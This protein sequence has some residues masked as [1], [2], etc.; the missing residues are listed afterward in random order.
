MTGARAILER[1]ALEP[2][3]P[4]L[5][6]RI[7]ELGE[8]L[9]QT[10][11]MQL[12]VERY[13]AI[14]IDRG[15]SLDTIDFP[16]NNRAW[17]DQRFTAISWLENESDRLKGIQ[18]ILHWTEAGPG[19]YYDDLGNP[20]RQPHLVR[21]FSFT[22]DPE[23]MR[24]VRSDFEEDLVADEPD[25]KTEGAR[26]VSWRDHAES[27]YDAPVELRYT[28]LDPKSNYKVRVVYAGDNPKR[29]IRLVANSSL[30]V[31]PYLSKPV[32]FK[33]ME[34]PLPLAATRTGALSLKWFGEQGLG[35]NGRGCQVSEVWLLKTAASASP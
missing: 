19:G 25:E 29:K 31:H 27:L 11:G 5:R 16:L 33:P 18:E 35:G 1:G 15:A 10:I 14:G 13:K 17:L 23:A 24:S 7:F 21:A 9:F 20:S 8:A 22:E 6:A 28:G 30:E 4:D 26:R 12:S 32:P 3:A 2:V 34:F